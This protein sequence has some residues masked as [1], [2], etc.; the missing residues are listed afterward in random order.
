M[1]VRQPKATSEAQWNF[2][3]AP[4][5][6]CGAGDGAHRGGGRLIRGML[7]EKGHD[8]AGGDAGR[9][10]K[11]TDDGVLAMVPDARTRCRLRTAGADNR[12]GSPENSVKHFVESRAATEDFLKSGDGLRDHVTDSDGKGDGYEFVLHHRGA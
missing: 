9:D 12:F 6:V 5:L 1:F 11:K 7:K 10:V 3:P 2:K 4:T 8:G